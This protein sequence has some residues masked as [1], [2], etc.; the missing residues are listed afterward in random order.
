MNQNMKRCLKIGS[1]GERVVWDALQHN[2]N[3]RTVF[4]VRL[5][6]KY[7]EFDVDFEIELMN[8]EIKWIEVK[9]DQRMHETRNVFYEI[10]SNEHCGTIGCFE[11]T[12]ADLMMIYNELTGIIYQIDIKRLRQ[13][14]RTNREK[15]KLVSGGDNA[16]GFL[17]NIDEL[18][19][20]QIAKELKYD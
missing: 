10:Q 20:Q 17:I 9:T 18:I 6:K 8:R 2:P 13:Y 4:D 1:I 7:Q 19:R 11:K 15:L 14:V 3:I 5:A 16:K 12:K